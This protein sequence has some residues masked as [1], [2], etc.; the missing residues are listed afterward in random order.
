MR[1]FQTD[2]ATG[3]ASMADATDC[4]L[5]PETT[6]ARLRAGPLP[7]ITEFRTPDFT[8]RPAASPPQGGGHRDR[9]RRPR[10]RGERRRLSR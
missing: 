10:S 8:Q 9:F 1:K 2:P 3:L 5:L 6:Q 7:L 4:V